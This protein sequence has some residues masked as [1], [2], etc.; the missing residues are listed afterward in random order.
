MSEEEEEIILDGDD[1]LDLGSSIHNSQVLNDENVLCDHLL[2]LQIVSNFENILP[3]IEISL[4]DDDCLLLSIPTS[5]LPLSMQAVYGFYREKTLLNLKIK[6]AESCNWREKPVL[7]EFSNPFFGQ[8]FIGK[9]LIQDVFNK[10]FSHEYSTGLLYRSY[11]FV[12]PSTIAP[13]PHMLQILLSHGIERSIA[14]NALSQCN[15]NLHQA[16]EFIL[17]GK[18]P[19]YIIMESLYDKCPLAYL[20]LEIAEAFFDVQDH[21]CI[22]RKDLESPGIKPSTCQNPVCVFA[23]EQLGVG[24]SVYQ[25]IARD[26]YAADLLVSVFSTALGTSYLV[27]SP[28]MELLNEAKHVLSTLPSM[29]DITRFFHND[30]E[31]IKKLGQKT[32][33]L[34]RWIL[35]SNRSHIITLPNALKLREIP[36]QSIQFLSLISTPEAE[37]DFMAL[38]KKYRSM[39]LW[40]GSSGDRW[41][42]ILRNGLKIGTG[43][44]LQQN[45]HAFGKGIYFARDSSVSCGYVKPAINQY[46]NSCLPKNFS[47]LSLCSIAKVKSL[48]THGWAYTITDESAVV[49]RFLFTVPPYFPCDIVSRPPR[50]VPTLDDF[51]RYTGAQLVR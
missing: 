36:Q 3:N 51:L 48:K 28:P 24:N 35:L 20:V 38:E 18:K 29:I 32:V 31:M 13:D 42:S 16:Q 4:S 17:T 15:N 43:T 6:L 19:D 11:P 14:E 34:L 9:P 46:T 40:H 30:T 37:K 49:V 22:C 7:L 25:E 12:F 27:P 47:L 5:I 8:N 10:F 26:P 41:Y 44:N 21:C 1:D 45:G 39:Y 2:L 33:D 50:Y 23:F